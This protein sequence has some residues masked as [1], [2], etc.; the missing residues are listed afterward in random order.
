MAYNPNF[1][2]AFNMPAKDTTINWVWFD[3]LQFIPPTG[4]DTTTFI[5]TTNFAR[6]ING[7]S[8]KAGDSVSVR[9]GYNGSAAA[10]TTN[11]L[12]KK[13]LTG[14]LYVDTAKVIGVKVDTLAKF[15]YQY[16][17]TKNAVEYREVYYD[18]FYTGTDPTLAEKRKAKVSAK[19][20]N[21]FVYDTVSSTVS[22]NRQ[23]IWQSTTKLARDV[24]VTFTCDLRPAYYTLA[25]GDSIY[26]VQ[27]ATPN[28][29]I[30]SR[31]SV[32]HWG[33]WINGPA[34]GGW[35]SSWGLV[36]RAITAQKMY[37]DG[38]HGDKVA[39][40]HIYS[41]QQWFYKD[42]I[43]N[44]VGQVFK[45]GLNG[46]D[47]SGGKGGFGNNNVQNINDA[48]TIATIASDFG[49]VNPQYFR[50]WNYNTHTT[51][52][53]K[54]EG[55]PL[56]YG[57]DQNYPNPFNPSTT[58][59]YSIPVSGRVTMRIFN[60]LGQVIATLVNGDMQN[61]GKYQ[62]TFDASR[63]S[64]GVYFYRIEAGTFS[65]VKKMMLLK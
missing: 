34:V 6:A 12:Q 37:D 60:V 20:T 55:V 3:N 48:D 46:G 42:S 59:N 4:V 8:I 17:L 45:F 62:V 15:Y 38:T 52:V 23:P 51:G 49:D 43:N 16:Y 31:D 2:Q 47:N 57:L 22:G 41:M 61:A 27:S 24:H 58:I 39:G 14:T 50:Y 28:L 40:D 30:S 56:T 32:Y 10:V 33:V 44:F 54:I 35:A 19:N 9:F 53:Q 1:Q 64:S 25:N 18:Y 7:N 11:L 26:D 5:F 36:L 21:L 63:Y 65:A 13:G 29:G